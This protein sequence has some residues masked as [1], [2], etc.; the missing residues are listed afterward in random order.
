MRQV[1]SSTTQRSRSSAAHGGHARRLTDDP[2]QPA[3]ARR[4]ASCQLKIARIDRLV[5]THPEQASNS[6]RCSRR[7]GQTRWISRSNSL[8][9]TASRSSDRGAH[10]RVRVDSAA[11]WWTSACLASDL[12]VG[13]PLIIRLIIQTILLYPSRAV[14]TDEAPNVSRLDPSGADQIDAEHPSRNRKVAGS[15]PTSGPITHSKSSTGLLPFPDP[16]TRASLRP[17]TTGH[18]TSMRASDLPAAAPHTASQH[19][20]SLSPIRPATCSSIER[21]EVPRCPPKGPTIDGK[22]GV[23]GSIP[24]GGSTKPMT[25]ANASDLG[26]R[27]GSAGQ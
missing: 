12:S 10:R 13:W 7:G 23:A 5:A 21:S 20:T 9:N 18:P 6:D 22:D 27:T 8:A 26:V 14:W 1:Q 16:R 2:R 15:N 11:A 25:S 3:S 4:R 19:P 24:A 17:A